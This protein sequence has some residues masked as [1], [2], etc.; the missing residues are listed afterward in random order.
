M[1]EICYK[2]LVSTQVFGLLSCCRLVSEAKD[3]E[4]AMFDIN[5]ALRIDVLVCLMNCFILYF[6]VDFSVTCHSKNF[7]VE[8]NGEII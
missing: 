1:F 8:T 3:R 6:G 4:D 2:N 7:L 5:E